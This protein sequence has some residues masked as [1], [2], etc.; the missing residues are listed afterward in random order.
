MPGLAMAAG[1]FAVYCTQPPPKLQAIC[2]RFSSGLLMGIAILDIFPL[3]D[4]RI[5]PKGKVDMANAIAMFIGFVAAI[6]AMYALDN[7]CEEPDFDEE[8]ELGD[9]SSKQREREEDYAN[10]SNSEPDRAALNNSN[11]NNISNINIGGESSTA[12]DPNPDPELGLNREAG[13]GARTIS[14][15]T[16]T[17]KKKMSGEET[18]QQLGLR[19]ANAT[20]VISFQPMNLMRAS[21]LP[22]ESI[23][24]AETSP[25]SRNNIVRA[26]S[27]RTTAG[28]TR[29]R[30]W[31][32]C[33]LFLGEVDA[34]K[35]NTRNTLFDR[36]STGMISS[37]KA[38]TAAAAAP[39]PKMVIPW[40]VIIAVWVDSCVDGMLIGLTTPAKEGGLTLA[41]A[42][43]LEMCFLG[44]SFTLVLLKTMRRRWASLLTLSPC[45]LLVLASVAAALCSKNLQDT[46]A[47]AG[48]LAFCLIALLFMIVEEL[49]VE[50]RENEF[51]D[52]WTV[53][54]W[55]YLGLLL[56]I[57]MDLFL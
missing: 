19:E 47:F 7:C 13:A 40:G 3:L 48:L 16:M 22:V 53:G 24:S 45:F 14:T 32:S 34:L 37:S 35:A 54:V 50:G 4:E 11:N 12:A 43:S 51:G 27:M 6:F 29:L 8:L 25:S 26:S 1:S 31:R 33:A 44:F 36:T 46:T 49:L 2:Q 55:F 20:A 42:T 17:M 23:S 57:A 21:T 30:K 15:I 5:K 52:L 38:P 56:S 18:E 9:E 10:N 41:V 28:T 39:R